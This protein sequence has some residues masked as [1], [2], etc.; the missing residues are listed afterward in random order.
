MGSRTIL[1]AWASTLLASAGA[2]GQVI[3]H[4]TFSGNQLGSHWSRPSQWSGSHT[5][6][7]GRLTITDVERPPGGEIQHNNYPVS[8]SFTP[9]HGDYSAKF[10]LGWQGARSRSVWTTTYG[11]PPSRNLGESV[12]WEPSGVVRGSVGQSGHSVPAPPAGNH[13]FEIAR[14]GSVTHFWLNG[15]YVGSAPVPPSPLYRVK[16]DVFR[17]G[18]DPYEPVYFD[19]VLI[20]ANPCYINCDRS[21]TEP[22]LTIDD[23]VCFIDLFSRGL[24]LPQSEQVAHYANCDGSTSAPVLNI[25]DF[26]CFANSFAQGC[27]Q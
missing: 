7:N 6:A 27:P 2:S 19:E 24:S 25:F 15:G 23:F 12:F 8:T 21:T 5:V 26:I 1:L 4:E 22:L 18:L 16:L 3:F 13:L 11:G 14:I 17:H 10:W 20:V 9:W